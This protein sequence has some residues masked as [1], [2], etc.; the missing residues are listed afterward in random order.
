MKL[1]QTRAGR[2][3]AQCKQVYSSAVRVQGTNLRTTRLDLARIRDRLQQTSE[4]KQDYLG[5]F[6]V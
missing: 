5:K 6:S 2:H 1:A 3:T 4:H